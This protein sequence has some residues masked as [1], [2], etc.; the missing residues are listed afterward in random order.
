MHQEM[1]CSDYF[2]ENSILDSDQLNEEEL[3]KMISQVSD[4]EEINTT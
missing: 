3:V 4:E 1:S 2:S